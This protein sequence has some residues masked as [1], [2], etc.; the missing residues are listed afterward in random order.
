MKRLSAAPLTQQRAR[1]GFMPVRI[2][3]EEKVP[4]GW[5]RPNQEPANVSLQF[6]NKLVYCQC[7][8]KIGT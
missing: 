5:F 4:Y 7:T 1:L 2:A 3:D 8:W 6:E